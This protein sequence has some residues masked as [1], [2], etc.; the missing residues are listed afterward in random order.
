MFSVLVNH[1]LYKH[2]PSLRFIKN[3][4]PHPISHGPRLVKQLQLTPF[5][6]S[7]AVSSLNTVK[8]TVLGPYP[9]PR[10]YQGTN[11][12]YVMLFSYSIYINNIIGLHSNL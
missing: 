10:I 11:K 7:I 8:P 1:L 4:V 12:Y 6:Q 2:A 9:L 5:K 3:A